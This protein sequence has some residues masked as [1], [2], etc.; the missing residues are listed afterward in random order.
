MTT[1]RLAAFVCRVSQD[2][3]PVEARERLKLNI[4]DTLGCTI[5]AL[6][7]DPTRRILTLI[8]ELGD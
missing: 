7:S 5:G 1:E 8:E 3:F 4:L 6:A 2:D